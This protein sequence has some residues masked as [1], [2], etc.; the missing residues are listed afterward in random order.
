MAA[1]LDT[2]SSKTHFALERLYRKLGQMDKVQTEHEIFEKL[3]EEEEKG[4][5]LSPPTSGLP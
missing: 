4:R 2:K 1:E 3:L 5:P